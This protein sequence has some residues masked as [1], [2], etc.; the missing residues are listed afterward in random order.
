MHGKFRKSIKSIS[1]TDKNDGA[2]NGMVTSLILLVIDLCS[3]CSQ[4]KLTKRLITLWLTSAKFCVTPCSVFCRP[5]MCN[6][7]ACKQEIVMKLTGKNHFVVT[8]NGLVVRI[9][10]PLFSLDG[11]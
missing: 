10:R 8:S 2:C 9:H 4:H 5:H 7:L 1:S 3:A 11:L 6:S